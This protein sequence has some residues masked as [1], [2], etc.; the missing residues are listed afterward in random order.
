MQVIC[1]G[2][3]TE[4][5]AGTRLAA[6]IRLYGLEAS[7]IVV[8]CDG[9]IIGRDEW[10]THELREGSRLELIRFVGGG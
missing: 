4:F 9:R 7:T 8:E 1:N 6:L 10:E 5:A 3:A 2:E